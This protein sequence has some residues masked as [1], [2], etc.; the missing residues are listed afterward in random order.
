MTEK[1]YSLGATTKGIIKSAGF[2]SKA[3]EILGSQG[4]WGGAAPVVAAGAIGATTIGASRVLDARDKSIAYK[5]MLDIN[6]TLK[7]HK[8]EKTQAYFNSM[9]RVSPVLAQDPYVS[10]AWVQNVLDNEDLHDNRPNY[11]L[12]SAVQD[13]AG[14]SK[15]LIDS[16]SK[17]QESSGI[18]AIGGNLS[19]LIQRGGEGYQNQLIRE[20]DKRDKAEAKH[21]A[22]EGFEQGITFAKQKVHEGAD[23]N[24]VRSPFL[25]KI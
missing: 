17:M 6:P 4:F 7:K 18:S 2:W 13:L 12:L 20:E 24:D 15:S 22:R 21:K 10:G 16:R 11:T 5:Q 3:K 1:S 25:P 23:I 19:E 14:P 9:Y 8:A